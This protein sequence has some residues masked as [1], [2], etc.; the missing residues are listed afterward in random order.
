MAFSISAGGRVPLSLLPWFCGVGKMMAAGTQGDQ[1]FFRISSEPTTRID[2]VDLEI[3][4]TSATL[5]AP[6]IPL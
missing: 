5:T 6:A 4:Q 2:V 3:R 1:I